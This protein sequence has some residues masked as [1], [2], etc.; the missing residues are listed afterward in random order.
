MQESLK[1]Y[2]RSY[3]PGRMRIRHPGLVDLKGEDQAAI[4]E[5]LKGIEGV[6]AVQ[7]NPVVGSMLL[8][9]DP[10]KISEEGISGYA[11]FFAGMIPEPA[12]KA[13]LP[14]GKDLVH[15]KKQIE[16]TGVDI[17]D[18]IAKYVVPGVKSGKRARRIAHNRIMLA[19]LG[20]SVGSLCLK[21]SI[22]AAFGWGFAILLGYHLYQHRKVL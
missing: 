2:V 5:Y 6:L 3:I 19:M 16:K 1:K 21:S 20:T 12:P 9:W 11:E 14:M 8:C 7:F 17:A 10:A 15:A 22:H 18:K 13:A 4:S